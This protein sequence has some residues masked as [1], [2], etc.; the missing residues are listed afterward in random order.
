MTSLNRKWSSARQSG[1]VGM[2]TESVNPEE[3]W[4]AQVRFVMPLPVRLPKRADH[5]CQQGVGGHRMRG[6]REAHSK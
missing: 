4:N 3:F 5:R 1:G 2:P 6:E